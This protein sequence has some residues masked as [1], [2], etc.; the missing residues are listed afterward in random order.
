MPDAGRWLLRLYHVLTLQHTHTHTLCTCWSYGMLY[1]FSDDS[2]KMDS[3]LRELSVESKAV[4]Q[5][6]RQHFSLHEYRSIVHQ[7]FKCGGLDGVRYPT[8]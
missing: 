3:D 4:G 8:N 7:M 6:I 1:C 5:L 2:T